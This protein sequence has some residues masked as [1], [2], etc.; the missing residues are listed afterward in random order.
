VTSTV[1]PVTA[2]I[3]L[4]PID[5]M[6]NVP[7]LDSLLDVSV[8]WPN[9]RQLWR[10]TSVEKKTHRGSLRSRKGIQNLHACFLEIPDVPRG[11]G[12]IVLKCCGSNHAVWQ[13]QL[14]SVLLQ[15]HDEFSPASANRGFPRETI[16]GLYNFP[17]PLLELCPLTSER[18]RENADAQFAQN[19]GVHDE[20][21]LVGAQPF[22]NGA[23]GQRLCRLANH[24]RIDQVSHR[25]LGIVMSLVVSLRSIGSN[26]PLTGQASSRF[27]NPSLR[28]RSFRFSRYSPRSIRST[29]NSWPDSMPS[30]RRIS[31][32]RIIWPFVET[33][34]FMLGKIGSYLRKV[35]SIPS[36]YP[37]SKELYTTEVRG[38]AAT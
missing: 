28:C 30:R 20:I 38:H 33:V 22:D 24:V 2:K 18:Q 16:Y 32:G 17:E 8:Y 25:I 12:E 27:T 36:Q 13:R 19:D 14:V 5:S 10:G 31:A 34:V 21:P 15:I 37:N 29:S 4:M 1:R 26:Q 7:R 6:E 9:E 35:K 23:A 11:N 3:Q